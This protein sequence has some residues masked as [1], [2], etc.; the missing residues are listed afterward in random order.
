MPPKRVAVADAEL[1]RD[2]HVIVE[3][4]AVRLVLKVEL[5][6]GVLCPFTTCV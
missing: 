5:N 4:T 1:F 2:F 6:G 3:M